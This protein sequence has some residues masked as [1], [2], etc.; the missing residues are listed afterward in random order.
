MIAPLSD[1]DWERLLAYGRAMRLLPALL[2]AANLA[3]HLL[4]AR[5][6]PF[7][8]EALERHEQVRR[9]TARSVRI[10]QRETPLKE[11]WAADPPARYA[12]Q[13]Q[14]ELGISGSFTHR[15]ETIAQFPFYY[16]YF[17]SRS[18][19]GSRQRAG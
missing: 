15:I 14:H 4:D 6:A 5:C 3:R 7:L 18:W 11:A 16:M 2:L 19:F 12:E 13:F 9:L 17:L 10:L 8:L 1:Q